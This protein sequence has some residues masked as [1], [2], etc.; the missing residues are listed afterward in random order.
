MTT[1]LVR[2]CNND[3]VANIAKTHNIHPLLAKML[4]LRGL[5]DPQEINAIL[6]NGEAFSLHDPFGLLGM[7]QC[8]DLLLNAI[9][10]EVQITVFGDY[11]VD[12][13]MA[14]TILYK[15]LKKLDANVNYYI[16]QRETEGYGLNI[17]AIDHL[18]EKG[19]G[20]LLTC[21]TGIAALKEVAYAKEQGLKVIVTDHHEIPF[22]VD[23][24]GIES[25]VLPPADAIVNAK[26]QNCTYPCKVLCGAG[27]A[28]KIAEAMYLETGLDWQA[29]EPEYLEL[30]AIA[31]VCD[32]VDLIGENHFLVKRGLQQLSHPQNKGIRALIDAAGITGKEIT[33][34]HIGFILGPCIN[35]SGRLEMA[36]M[37]VELFL[38]E[39]ES[40]CRELA[41]NL[42][43]LN[44]SRKD[45]T[46]SG[47]KMA[48][49]LIETGAFGQ[50]KVL[51]LYLDGL[52]ES[53]AGIVA[54]RIKEKYHRPTIILTNS[55]EEGFVKGSGRSIE[56]YHMFQAISAVKELLTVFGGHPMAAGLT[57]PKEHIDQFRARLNEQI[58]L[59]W[60]EMAPVF[61]IDHV[62]PLDC[63][64]MK[65]LEVLSR[66]EP[67][68]KSNPQPV[69]ADK[70]LQVLKVSCLGKEQQ[71]IRLKI[72]TVKNMIVEAILFGQKDK[73]MELLEKA[74]GKHCWDGLLQE[75][76]AGEKVFFDFLYTVNLN[77]YQNK[78]SCQIQIKDFRLSK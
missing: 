24:N 53:V 46:S 69:F 33:C 22:E 32:L 61:M 47:A 64:N 12:G 17:A 25:P 23:E 30:A 56:G 63:C 26:N 37:A 49:E 13:I 75:S 74:Y 45:L 77:E 44:Q 9:E 59:S 38:A 62:M 16:P 67:Y 20:L 39:E 42:V 21:D 35:A 27:V 57:M 11:D 68:G 71:V 58:T 14:T 52:P 3:A 10:E 76:L 70:N 19:A 65:L 72:K 34:F 48:E 55:Y 54:G 28:Y 2:Q 31:T 60:E 50:D 1:W 15:L 7:E 78:R 51:V 5:T 40:R 8:C 18:I 29:D 43:M 6:S 41:A 66:L 73:F 4:Y 36:S